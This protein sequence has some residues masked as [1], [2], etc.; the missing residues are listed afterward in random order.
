MTAVSSVAVV[1]R[2]ITRGL[3][4]RRLGNDDYCMRLGSASKAL[5]IRCCYNERASDCLPWFIT[6]AL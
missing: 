5:V 1:L 3:I 4:A 2:L 6:I